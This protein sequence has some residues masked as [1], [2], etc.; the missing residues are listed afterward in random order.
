MSK[1]DTNQSGGILVRFEYG[2]ARSAETKDFRHTPSTGRSPASD[3]C[4]SDEVP[5]TVSCSGQNVVNGGFPS[6]IEVF[7]MSEL[8]LQGPH[9]DAE[10][11]GGMRAIPRTLFQGL[12]DG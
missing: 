10:P 2:V 9:G 7:V 5:V 11:L 3:R 12:R 4:H 6:A 8:A 1:G